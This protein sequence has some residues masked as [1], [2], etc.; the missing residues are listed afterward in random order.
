ML[1]VFKIGI[2]YTMVPVIIIRFCDIVASTLA[3]NDYTGR[4]WQ[5]LICAAHYWRRRCTAILVITELNS[6]P[7]LVHTIY[8]LRNKGAKGIKI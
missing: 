5:S 4:L 6:K 2:P 7:V 3:D 1:Q 8:H